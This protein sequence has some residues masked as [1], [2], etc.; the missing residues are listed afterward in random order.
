MRGPAVMGNSSCEHRTNKG[1]MGRTVRPCDGQALAHTVQDLPDHLRP[2]DILQRPWD[3][4]S[5]TYG[6]LSVELHQTVIDHTV[7]EITGE[8]YR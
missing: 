3:S 1:G 7:L 5:A 6:D 4:R 8:R 2:G